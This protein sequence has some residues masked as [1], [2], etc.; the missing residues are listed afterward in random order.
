MAQKRICSPTSA[1]GLLS[2]YKRYRELKK[3]KRNKLT[4]SSRT[5]KANYFSEAI[6]SGNNVVELWKH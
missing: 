6:K 5:S 4:S 1:N 3:P 2:W